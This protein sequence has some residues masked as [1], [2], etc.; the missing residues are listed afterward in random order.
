M[1]NCPEQIGP[2][3]AQAKRKYQ[4]IQ[5]TELGRQ[6]MYF[7]LIVLKSGDLRSRFQ[8]I[9]SL[10]NTCLLVLKWYLLTASSNMMDSDGTFS[11][12]PHMMDKAR[13][14]LEPLLQGV[15]PPPIAKT[16]IRGPTY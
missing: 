10:V 9:Q 7:S 16:S 4:G 2:L 14:S 8:Q 5:A 15:V 12:H 13:S 11:L 1:E 6:I 3:S